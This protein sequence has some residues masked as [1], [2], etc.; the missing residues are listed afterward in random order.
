MRSCPCRWRSGPAPRQRRTHLPMESPHTLFIFKASTSIQES[1]ANRAGARARRFI[2][3]RLTAG[4]ADDG[5]IGPVPARQQHRLAGAFASSAKGQGSASARRCDRRWRRLLQLLAGALSA[6]AR[7]DAPPN[8]RGR[9][10][11]PRAGAVTDMPSA[12]AYAVARPG[13]PP[14]FCK[15]VHHQRVKPDVSAP[16][17]GAS[18]VGSAR[19]TARR[20]A[21]PLP[22][23]AA[24]RP[25]PARRS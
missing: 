15:H 18:S 5:G 1:S 17:I 16:S 20:S 19:R 3:R 4:K 2:F 10:L 6:K 8:R 9:R 21:P 13:A 12:A 14:S 22:R 24:P 25:F 11:P 23:P 7:A